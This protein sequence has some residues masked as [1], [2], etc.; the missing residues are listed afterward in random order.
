MFTPKI[1]F[2]SLLMLEGT[3]YGQE[4]DQTS[5][6]DLRV[7]HLKLGNLLKRFGELSNDCRHPLIEVT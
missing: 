6:L 4:K 7:V 3:C 5:M 2:I 1:R